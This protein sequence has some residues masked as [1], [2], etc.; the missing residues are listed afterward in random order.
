MFQSLIKKGIIRNLIVIVGVAAVGLAST[1]ALF[2]DVEQSQQGVFVVG[3]LDMTVKE[4]GEVAESIVVNNIGESATTNG[5]K[6]WT[7]NN[8]GSLPGKLTFKLENVQN[9]ENGCNEPESLVDASC[10]DPGESEGE[11]GQSISTVVSL[12]QGEGFQPV[13]AANLA[14]DQANQYFDQWQANAGRVIIPA[15]GSVDVKFEWS[16]DQYSLGNE[17]QSDSIMFDVVFEL[18]QI[19]PG[20]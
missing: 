2:R 10:N 5:G 20:V 16:A 15:S 12:D 14:S 1:Q 18:E 8:V 11:L 6:T 9:F 17:V 3:T 4:G 13:V 19:V 7:I